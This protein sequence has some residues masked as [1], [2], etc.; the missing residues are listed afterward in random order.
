MWELVPLSGSSL[1]GGIRL[2]YWMVCP[3]LREKHCRRAVCSRVLSTSYQPAYCWAASGQVS[4][5]SSHTFTLSSAAC[6]DYVQP[7]LNS[8]WCEIKS[9]CRRKNNWITLH[10]SWKLALPPAFPRRILS[11][12]NQPKCSDSLFTAE[13]Q[14]EQRYQFLSVCAVFS[15]VQT[16]VW[17][18]PMFGIFTVRTD[19]DVW[20]CV[21]GLYRHRRRV[22]TGSWL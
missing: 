11:A 17:R 20:D 1:E 15:R 19:V 12:R 22:C 18:L 14:Q 4:L 6:S 13:K 21:R 3:I 9:N 5:S 10:W 7:F 16:M 2:E 8:G